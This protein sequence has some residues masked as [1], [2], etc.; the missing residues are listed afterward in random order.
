MVWQWQQAL[1]ATKVWLPVN[2]PIPPVSRQCLFMRMTMGLFTF[3]LSSQISHS[4]YTRSCIAVSV[5]SKKSSQKRLLTFT[6]VLIRAGK[7]IRQ[8]P[9]KHVPCLYDE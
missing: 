8:F 9:S 6:F 7:Q 5:R 4:T 2:C 3:T 1:T